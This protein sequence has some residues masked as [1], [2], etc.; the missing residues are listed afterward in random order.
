[1]Q[2]KNNKGFSLIEVLVTTVVITV[3]L[4]ALAPLQITLRSAIPKIGE[5]M[6]P[7]SQAIILAKDKMQ[8]LEVKSKNIKCQE[9]PPGKEKKI[10]DKIYRVSHKFDPEVDDHSI[11]PHVAIVTVSWDVID[12]NN[13][14]V[15]TVE[16]R[17][18]AGCKK[19][20]GTVNNLSSNP[21]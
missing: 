12:G 16:L 14:N 13:S 1:M 6:P 21:P 10:G 5:N 11:F 20:G 2:Q 8:E 3:G 17:K 15:K 4:L 18:N 19:G 9:N 7:R